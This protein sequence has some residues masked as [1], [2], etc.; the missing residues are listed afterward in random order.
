MLV[1]SGGHNFQ[2]SFLRA[3]VVFPILGADFLEHFDMWVDLKR[4]RLRRW[5]ASPLSLVAAG[6]LFVSSG[7]VA[8]RGVGV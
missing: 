8:D 6:Q 7:I 4:R 2:W 1:A 3:K 5:G